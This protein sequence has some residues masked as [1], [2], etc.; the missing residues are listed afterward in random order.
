MCIYILLC[1]KRW[2]AGTLLFIPSKLARWGINLNC[3]SSLHAYALTT[4]KI[5]FH[6]RFHSTS[7]FRK[8]SCHHVNSDGTIWINHDKRHK[9]KSKMFLPLCFFSTNISV[10]IR[11]S[12]AS[13]LFPY[14]LLY[15]LA[16]L[17][18]FSF[19]GPWDKGYCLKQVVGSQHYVSNELLTKNLF[20]WM[21]PHVRNQ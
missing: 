17:S 1:T 12:F 14:S 3:K 6:F 20:L 10:G 13:L 15:L 4:C 16:E 5:L 9:N 2:L 8:N 11:L 21:W 18:H 19:V 7:H